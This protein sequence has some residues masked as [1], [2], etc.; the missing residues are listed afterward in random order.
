MLELITV[1]LL[2]IAGLALFLAFIVLLRVLSHRERMAMIER[3]L[4]VDFGRWASRERQGA[5]LLR[6][7]LITGLVG[8][9]LTLGL[10]PVGFMLPPRI[11]SAPFHLGPWLL[12][13]LMPLAVGVALILS[14]YLT[15]PRRPVPPFAVPPVDE[16]SLQ[17]PAADQD[18]LRHDGWL[19]LYRRA[20]D[21]G[22]Q[23][24]PPLLE[25]DEL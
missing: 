9:A 22:D 10:Y 23:G 11:A 1:G 8:L 18:R 16:P 24:E 25:E 14:H 5:A 20:A 12:P 21:P 4:P 7:G 17:L 2:W 15:A 13:G 3:G 19:T 6:A